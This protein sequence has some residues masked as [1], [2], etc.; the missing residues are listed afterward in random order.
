M[1]SVVSAD[2]GPWI[3]GQCARISDGTVRTWVPI[4]ERAH[5]I[6]HGERDV[7]CGTPA[8]N[9]VLGPRGEIRSQDFLDPSKMYDLGVE[10]R[11]RQLGV[12]E[13][14]ACW[15]DVA[16]K[17]GCVNQPPRSS[18]A[19]LAALLG[20]EGAVDRLLPGAS[21]ALMRDHRVLCMRRNA[22]IELVTLW[23]DAT[24]ASVWPQDTDGYAGCALLRTGTVSC[25]GDN[26]MGQRGQWGKLDPASPTPIRGLER[27][28]EVSAWH[29]RACARK[30]GQV[31]CWGAA[32]QR[33]SG[34]AALAASKGIRSCEVDTV[35]TREA[36][37]RYENTQ[38][39]CHDGS[40]PTQ[41][42]D[43]MCR[44]AWSAL[45]PEVIYKDLG[46][47]CD[48]SSDHSSIRWAPPTRVDG[49]DDAVAL[50]VGE[51]TCVLTARDSVVCFGFDKPG[52]HEV[53]RFTAGPVVVPPVEATI[54]VPPRGVS[55]VVGDAGVMVTSRRGAHTLHTVD[56]GLGQ[57]TPL[58]VDVRDAVTFP[59]RCLLHAGG[60]VECDLANG[61][62]NTFPTLADTVRL[63]WIG[64]QG[65]VLGSTG[66]LQCDLPGSSSSGA[67]AALRLSFAGPIIAHDGF[68]A[69]YVGGAVRCL[70][71]Y[72]APAR[73]IWTGITA[74]AA[75]PIFGGA[76]ALTDQR[77]VECTGYNG[78]FQRG[79]EL[80]V[81]KRVTKVAG[82]S[83]V[84][85]L[86]VS[87]S[88]ACALTAEGEVWCWGRATERETGT[89]AYDAAKIRTQCALDVK[90]MD[91][92]ATALAK[93]RAECR[94]ATPPASC[95]PVKRLEIDGCEQPDGYGPVRRVA[96]PMKIPG[97]DHAIAIGAGE[98]RTCAITQIGTKPARLVCWGR[99]FQGLDAVPA[100]VE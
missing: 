93:S 48:P 100:S 28:D 94:G 45:P 90:A 81:T 64:G 7:R 1:T 49:I 51:R 57:G 33:Q 52:L 17:V 83:A 6:P 80:A 85:Q 58:A 89:A 68:C 42:D 61:A 3:F 2:P 71:S 22:A 54:V 43:P 13:R 32:A 91:R 96:T 15:V 38:R 12:L 60:A 23:R 25:R 78:T 82:L 30:G 41:G 76:C 59:R 95:R 98:G 35:A 40:R 99:G 29:D 27:F 75:D 8:G 5:P 66:V 87:S 46:E 4:P 20:A 72:D 44:E 67:R 16:G 65:C 97:L 36:K 92:T 62:T 18:A 63:S 88:H 26:S 34:D 73:Q 21:C 31:W 86:A 77:T 55:L 53:V 37:Q 70:D 10:P 56:R 79:D 74:L 9:L 84:T 50:F 11:A 14:S 47:R 39:A 19:K 24:Q 69:L